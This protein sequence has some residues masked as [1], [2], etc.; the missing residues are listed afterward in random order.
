MA[1]G[2]GRVLVGLR[3]THGSRRPVRVGVVW[4]TPGV[5]LRCITGGLWPKPLSS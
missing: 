2:F 4:F 1:R 3:Q 5:A